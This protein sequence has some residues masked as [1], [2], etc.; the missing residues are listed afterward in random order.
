M[1]D[2]NSVE[3]WLAALQDGVTDDEAAR[4][5]L[6][7][8]GLRRAIH[9]DDIARVLCLLTAVRLHQLGAEVR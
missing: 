8:I 3:S 2:P 5:L 7:S 1:A 9:P 4:T 6:N